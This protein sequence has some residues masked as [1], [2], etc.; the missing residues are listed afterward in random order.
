MSEQ[1]SK[2]R[3]VFRVY[4]FPVGWPTLSSE[5][6]L[7]SRL[8]QACLQMGQKD[9]VTCRVIPAVT[10]GVFKEK[11]CADESKIEKV[12]ENVW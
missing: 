8:G 6:K 11:K 1:T 5:N 12:Y 3:P 10:V 4:H 2:L 7:L 9:L